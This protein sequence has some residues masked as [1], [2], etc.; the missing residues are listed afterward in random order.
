MNRQQK[1]HVVESLRNSFTQSNASIL[2]GYRGLSVAQLQSL[3][4]GLRQH[5]GAMRVTKTRLMK[6]A[7]QGLEGA[8]DMAPYF[9]DQV[10]LVFSDE[11]PSAVAKALHSF[12]KENGSL[13]IVAGCLDERLLDANAVVTIASLPSKEVLIAKLLGTLQAPSQKLAFVLNMQILRLLWVLKKV[14]EQKK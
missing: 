6:L 1:E 2:V 14:A 11:E 8:Q 7:V 5:G 4:K 13:S 12:S 3:R 10:A 9:K